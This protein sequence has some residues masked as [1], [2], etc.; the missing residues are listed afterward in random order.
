MFRQLRQARLDG[1]RRRALVDVPGKEVAG[2]DAAERQHSAAPNGDTRPDDRARSEPDLVLNND[3][4]GHKIEAAS[5]PVM[6]S[7]AEI[8]TLRQTAMTA[9]AD[10][11]KVVEPDT[12]AVWVGDSS[13]CSESD[14]IA[15]CWRVHA[16]AI[17]WDGRHTGRLILES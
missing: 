3:R 5:A 7:R 16:S 15:G 10:F 8:S 1:D 4:L 13:G 14:A 12:F 17:R 11:G 2:R 6:T 9:D